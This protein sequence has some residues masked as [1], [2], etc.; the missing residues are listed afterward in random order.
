MKDFDETTDLGKIPTVAP[1]SIEWTPEMDEG[2]PEPIEWT[3]GLALGIEAIDADHRAL[4]ALYNAIATPGRP[5]DPAS[6][7]SL[8]Q[9]AYK[10]TAAHFE[11]E[12]QLMQ[13]A[14]YAQFE[15]HRGEHRKLLDELDK[16]VDEW[17]EKGISAGELGMFMQRWLLHHITGMD[18]HMGRELR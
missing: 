7:A 17:S 8:L 14:G 12:E 2:T 4:I 11:R 10:F 6:F 1:E 18:A 3:P 16:Q 5:V 9:E 13:A 15:V